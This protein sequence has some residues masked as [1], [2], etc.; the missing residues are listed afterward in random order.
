MLRLLISIL[1]VRCWHFCFWNT[2]KGHTHTIPALLHASWKEFAAWS[3]QQHLQSSTF[4]SFQ[5]QKSANKQ[6]LKERFGQCMFI[7]ATSLWILPSR[8]NYR[9]PLLFVV[10][11][12][13]YSFVCNSAG[14][15]QLPGS[16]SFLPLTT[17]LLQILS[18]IITSYHHQQSSIFAFMQCSPQRPIQNLLKFCL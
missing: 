8:K 9:S 11:P 1:W 18:L 17:L 10:K 5:A 13:I 16:L 3:V 15:V 2:H 6:D 12:P 4:V 7:W 14:F